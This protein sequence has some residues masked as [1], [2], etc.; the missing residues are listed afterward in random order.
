LTPPPQQFPAEQD[1]EVFRRALKVEAAKV[2]EA[3]E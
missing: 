3:K 1:L 2:K